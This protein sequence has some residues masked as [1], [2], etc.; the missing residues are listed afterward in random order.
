MPR[1]AD[2]VRASITQKRAPARVSC[3]QHCESLMTIQMAPAISEI[4]MVDGTVHDHSRTLPF[5]VYGGAH[6]FDSQHSLD[7]PRM[8]ESTHVARNFR[9]STDT[10]SIS[11]SEWVGGWVAHIHD[12]GPPRAPN[13]AWN[14]ITACK[15]STCHGFMHKQVHQ[16]P[17]TLSR[18]MTDT[19]SS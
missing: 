1:G 5:V 16:R 10:S 19:R 17:T 3:A 2:H 6:E 15:G 7:H 9:A 18:N 13:L 8:I 11:P 4:L 14:D 12:F